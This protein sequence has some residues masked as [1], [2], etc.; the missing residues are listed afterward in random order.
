MALFPKQRFTSPDEFRA[1]LLA[2]RVDERA[3]QVLVRLMGAS[4]VEPLLDV[5]TASVDSTT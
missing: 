5:R 1:L 2:G 3:L 4:A